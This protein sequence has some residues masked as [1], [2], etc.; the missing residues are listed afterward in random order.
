M[1]GE[2]AIVF[3][4]VS[5]SYTGAPVIVDADFA[6]PARSFTS[7]VGPNGGGKTTLL[8]LMLGLLRPNEG[9]IRVLGT[10]P[11][12][13][14]PFIGYMP[15]YIHFDRYFPATVLDIVLMGRMKQWYPLGPFGREDCE[16]ARAALAMVRMEEFSHRTFASLSGG[17]R[18]RILI[19]RALATEPRLLLLDEPTANVDPAAEFDL[20]QL[21]SDMSNRITCVIVSHDLGFVSP[22]VTQVVCVNRQVMVHDTAHLTGELIMSLYGSDVRMVRHHH[23]G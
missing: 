10:T 14:R 9:E 23:R 3:R 12:H 6:I 8:K 17:Q 16:R 15:Q 13:A 19:A 1:R 5:F 4:H 20:L 7:I 18:Q 21:L 2:E 22:Y 11:I